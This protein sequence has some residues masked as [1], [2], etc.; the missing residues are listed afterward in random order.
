M[1]ARLFFYVPPYVPPSIYLE[2]EDRLFMKFINITGASLHKFPTVEEVAVDRQLFNEEIKYFLQKFCEKP[3]ST[4]VRYALEQHINIKPQHKNVREQIL[5]KGLVHPDVIE[6]DLDPSQLRKLEEKHFISLLNRIY[7]ACVTQQPYLPAYEEL[8]KF[9]LDLF[10]RPA[11]SNIHV[12]TII[13]FLSGHCRSLFTM[14]K[15]DPNTSRKVIKQVAPERA[16][17]RGRGSST[18]KQLLAKFVQEHY[19]L[20]PIGI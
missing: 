12:G 5:E 4:F 18:D 13:S 2:S 20:T 9:V 19:G 8:K 14:A 1:I 15:L 7:G 17:R 16:S 6:R 3:A 10:K 11:L